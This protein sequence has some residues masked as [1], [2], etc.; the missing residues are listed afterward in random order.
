MCGVQNGTL[1]DPMAGSGTAAIAAARW[2][3]RAILTE[4]EASYIEMIQKRWNDFAARQ[5]LPANDDE[6]GTKPDAD[7]DLDAAE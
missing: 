6:A 4:R 7:G 5:Q 3:M 2:G 1:L